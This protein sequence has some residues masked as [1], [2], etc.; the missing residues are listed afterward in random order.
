[1]AHHQTLILT[2]WRPTAC[3]DFW[4]KNC[5]NARGFAWEFLQSGMRHRSSKS[6]KRPGKSSSL[7]S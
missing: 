6:L 5:L 4:K 3:G 1:M 7:H 2:L